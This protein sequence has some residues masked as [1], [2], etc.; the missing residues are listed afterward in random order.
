MC[1]MIMGPIVM[2]GIVEM[3]VR[4]ENGKERRGWLNGLCECKCVCAKVWRTVLKMTRISVQER[5][6]CDI[7][8]TRSANAFL[9]M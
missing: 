5:H 9:F 6:E 1:K 4:S 8:V 2:C 3:S 7:R